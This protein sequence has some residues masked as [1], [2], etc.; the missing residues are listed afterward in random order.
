MEEGR[1]CHHFCKHSGGQEV[2]K[3]ERNVYL[4]NE[5]EDDNSLR[6]VAQEGNWETKAIVIQRAWRATLYRRGSWSRNCEKRS[7]HRQGEEVL[8]A[9]QR[10]V[11]DDFGQ[12]CPG[13]VCPSDC[14]SMS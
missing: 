1:K 3:M 2:L 10:A 14:K 13:E 5:E 6:H 11:M 4:P 8:M 7:Y 9:H 12:P